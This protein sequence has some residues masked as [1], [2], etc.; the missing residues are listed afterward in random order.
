MFVGV[1]MAV[2]CGDAG[3]SDAPT[4]SADGS[5]LLGNLPPTVPTV[6]RSTTSTAAPPTTVP[7]E[8]TIGDLVTGNRV[9]A[10]GDSI[11]AS[12]SRRLGGELCDTLVPLGWAS[13]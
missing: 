2:A 10:I 6:V 12:A 5:V 7:A 3:S 1:L 11:F 4:S 9:I 8:P 13:K